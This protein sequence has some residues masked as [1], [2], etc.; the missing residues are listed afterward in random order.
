MWSI[1]PSSVIQPGGPFVE[2][3][4]GKSA[5]WGVPP[6][7]DGKVAV[8]AP[9]GA[10]RHVNV[11]VHVTRKMPSLDSAEQ[12]ARPLLDEA[13]KLQRGQHGEYPPDGLGES[14]GERVELEGSS[15]QQVVDALEV[16]SE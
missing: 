16:R 5:G 3:R 11:E 12:M 2:H 9:P 6:H 10:E 7:R 8:T 13:L 14:L 4:A 1:D 15:L